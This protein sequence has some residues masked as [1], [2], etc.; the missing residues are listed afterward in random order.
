MMISRGNV[1]NLEGNL[2][3]CNFVHHERYMKSLGMNQN[4]RYM[5]LALDLF[6]RLERK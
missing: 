1:R 2:L 4:L 3:E 5:K 6:N